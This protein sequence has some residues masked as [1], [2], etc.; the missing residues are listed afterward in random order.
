MVERAF[1]TVVSGL[2]RSGTSMMMRMLVAGGL[3]LLSDG[4]RSADEDNPEGYFEY[5]PVKSL[6]T[7]S[8]WLPAARGKVLK[9]ISELLSHLP[10]SEEYRV[11]FML[12]KVEEV[13]AS[14]AKMLARRGR[15]VPSAAEDESMGGV[16]LR[17]LDRVT[18]WLDGQSHMK[19][20][21]VSYNQMF[22]R[23]PAHAARVD[24]FL[25]GGLDTA[26]MAAA[27]DPSLYRQRK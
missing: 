24:A 23:G 21:Y 2:P 10:A 27:V 4:L 13:L 15:P 16:L 18:R 11:I 25:G 22:S 19:A 14:Q 6:A 7:D 9:V 26:A 3:P 17:H 8:S 1:V 5:E 12:R 20:L